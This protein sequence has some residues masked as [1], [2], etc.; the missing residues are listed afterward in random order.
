M[1]SISQ[2]SHSG[3]PASLPLLPLLISPFP[4]SHTLSHLQ[5]HYSALIYNPQRCF[6]N[7]QIPNY[8]IYYQLSPCPPFSLFWHY[9]WTL[10]CYLYLFPSQYTPWYCFILL[11][12]P[13][14]SHLKP[15]PLPPYPLFS[16][17]WEYL[18]TSFCYHYIPLS[19][20]TPRNGSSMS[21][22]PWI[23]FPSPCPCPPPLFS[24]FEGI[25]EHFF[26]YISTVSHPWMYIHDLYP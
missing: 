10:F 16:L 1:C 14:T 6:F 21:Y 3:H 23:S 25:Y 8:S 26:A 19:L 12:E 4:S 24:L 2:V 5:G 15:L 17:F 13:W 7:F 9:L 20:H 11:P 18:W 22:N